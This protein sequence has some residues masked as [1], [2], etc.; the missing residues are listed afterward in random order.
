MPL[1][2]FQ[3]GK[4]YAILERGTSLAL[5]DQARHRPHSGDRSAEAGSSS[6]HHDDVCDP[7]R[8]RRDWDPLPT[9]LKLRDLEAEFSKRQSRPPTE[10]ELAEA[11]RVAQSW[12]GP[13]PK[14]PASAASV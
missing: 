14:E 7:Q 12:R 11:D 2:V 13:P 10:T 6:E 1:S 9:A 3:D 4:R 8:C 5:R